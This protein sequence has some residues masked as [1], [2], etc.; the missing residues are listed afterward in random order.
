MS[1]FRIKFNSGNLNVNYHYVP[2]T[3]GTTPKYDVYSDHVLVT[4]HNEPHFD[5]CLIELNSRIINWLDENEVEYYYSLEYTTEY[6][7]C[8]NPI[9]HKTENVRH[10][11]VTG[12]LVFVESSFAIPFKIEFL[13]EIQLSV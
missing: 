6:S 10:I 4:L 3:V 1:I 9:S 8:K 2:H 11:R 5:K 7:L 13:K 12:A